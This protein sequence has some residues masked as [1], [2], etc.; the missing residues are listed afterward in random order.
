MLWNLHSESAESYFKCW[1]TAVKLINDFPRSTFTYLVEGYFTQNQTS[2]RTQ[3]L[4]RY[5]R[6]F[7]SLLNSPSQE[8]RLL[9]NLA[10][11]DPSFNTADMLVYIRELTE[12]S[13]WNFSPGSP[14]NFV[15]S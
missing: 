1:N 11:R 12:L 2:L 6:F 9:V 13:P 15:G 8:V 14:S 3:V 5:T 10:A 7:H 4:A